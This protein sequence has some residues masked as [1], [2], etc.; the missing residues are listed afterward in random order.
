MNGVLANV[1]V[2]AQFSSKLSRGII[3]QMIVWDTLDV[4]SI[5]FPNCALGALRYCNV[6]SSIYKAN[7]FCFSGTVFYLRFK[8]FNQIIVPIVHPYIKPKRSSVSQAP[9]HSFFSPRFKY[10]NQRILPIIS[11]NLIMFKNIG[12]IVFAPNPRIS[13][14]GPEKQKI[15]CF[16]L[17]GNILYY[18]LYIKLKSTNTFKNLN[19]AEN[20]N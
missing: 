17:I 16:G 5:L 13:K 20:I 10:F 14:K 7:I 9:G 6:C 3:T 2:F 12:H 19:I 15:T 18:T 11:S 4:F 8:Y 1:L